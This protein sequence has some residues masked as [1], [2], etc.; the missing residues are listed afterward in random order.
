MDDAGWGDSVTLLVWDVASGGQLGPPI[1]LKKGLVFSDF[2]PD[3]KWV[4]TTTFQSQSERSIVC[5]WDV[6]TG[7]VVIRKILEGY[8]VAGFI[9]DGRHF[10]TS[11]FNLLSNWKED[12][13]I[14]RVWDSTTGESV[15][16]VNA[17]GGDRFTRRPIRRRGGSLFIGG[18]ND[19]TR[20][21]RDGTL[22]AL[23]PNGAPVQNCEN[24]DGGTGRRTALRSLCCRRGVQRGRELAGH[25]KQGG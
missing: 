3:G 6:D 18:P 20:T 8:W 13:L 22:V 16:I 17:P 5:R 1:Q 19:T 11:L 9:G 14:L 12:D 4:L 2:S 7:K 21:S 23:I 24:D 10:K 15:G 25:A